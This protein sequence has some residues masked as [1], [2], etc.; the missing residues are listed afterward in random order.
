M[1]VIGSVPQVSVVT[2]T[3]AVIDRIKAVVCAPATLARLAVV[4]AHRVSCE[5]W[6]KVELLHDFRVSFPLESVTIHPEYVLAT[7]E[8]APT[9]S[10]ADLV[11]RSDAE[12]V[13]VELKTF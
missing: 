5:G 9:R 2:L 3:D 13:I 4:S 10:A 1:N 7:S 12:E 8:S 6:L 11:V